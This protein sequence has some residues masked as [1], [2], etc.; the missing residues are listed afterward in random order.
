MSTTINP[1]NPLPRKKWRE[2]T[3]ISTIKGV[4]FVLLDGSNT[5][6]VYNT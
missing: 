3:E 4:G 1:A 5:S 2:L 6:R